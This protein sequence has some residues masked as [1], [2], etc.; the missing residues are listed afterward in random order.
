[1]RPPASGVTVGAFVEEYE[2]EGKVVDAGEVVVEVRFLVSPDFY[3][4]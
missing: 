1:M 4:V 2:A 3:A